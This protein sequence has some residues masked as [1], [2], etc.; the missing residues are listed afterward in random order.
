MQPKEKVMKYIYTNVT[1]EY[2]SVLLATKNQDSVGTRTFAPGASLELDYQ[3]LNLYVPG[4]LSC[5]AIDTAHV[6]ETIPVVVAPKEEPIV[7]EVPEPVIE[8]VIPTVVNE[9]VPP[10]EPITEPVVPP[11]EVLPPTEPETPIVKV[12]APKHAAK[13]A[14]K[15]IKKK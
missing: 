12:A 9:E 5:I 4:I 13:V 6:A 1:H 7:E 15:P 11:V 8:P 3:G 2:Q 14:A 10:A